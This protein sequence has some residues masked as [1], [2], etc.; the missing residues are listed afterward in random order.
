MDLDKEIHK[1]DNLIEYYTNHADLSK[2]GVRCNL[3]A[4]KETRKELETRKKIIKER[5]IR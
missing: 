5:N 3:K 2:Y 4:L 1:L